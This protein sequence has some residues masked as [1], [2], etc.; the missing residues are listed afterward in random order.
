MCLFKVHFKH[1]CIY[2]KF[3]LPAF[4]QEQKPQLLS[5][6]KGFPLVTAVMEHDDGVGFFQ[7]SDKDYG[8]LG[9]LVDFRF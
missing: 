6:S 5:T 3:G 2:S 7:N 4:K 1:E 9:A 8:L